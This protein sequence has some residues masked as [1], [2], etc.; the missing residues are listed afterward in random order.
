MKIKKFT[1]A[2]L[3]MGISFSFLFTSSVS[4]SEETSSANTS[5]TSVI[6]TNA[7]PG[8][9]QGP[10]ITST[11]AVVME[12]S[13]NTI[14]YAKNMDQPLHPGSAVKIM[15]ALLALETC[16]LQDEVTMT[17]T[18]LAG[19][20]DGGAHISA[21]MDEVFTVEQC[22]YGIMAASANDLS[23]QIAEYAGGSV[24]N[25]VKMMNTRAAELGCTSTTFTNPTGMTDENQISTAH[26]M[27]LIMKAAIDNEEFRKIASTLSWTIPATNLSG[28]RTLTSKFS[29][30]DPAGTAYYEGILG[31]REGYTAASLSTL[32]CAAERDDCILIAVVLEGGAEQTIPEAKTL[33]DYG[34]QNFQFISPGKDDFSVLSGGNVLLPSTISEDMLQTTETEVNGETIRQYLYEDILLGTAIVI[35]ETETDTSLMENHEKQL[36]KARQFTENKSIVPYIVILVIFLLLFAAAIWQSRKIIKS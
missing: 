11:A 8:W 29:M 7:I 15:T 10:E 19:A 18:G 34:F 27:A 6:S 1:A 16:N 17:A 26:D 35:P 3:T 22:L 32:A 24:E 31:G 25:F 28:E 13:T 5:S 12:D 20:T 2:L 21:Q 33:L 30:L 14:L 9:P 23:L 36:E 4:A